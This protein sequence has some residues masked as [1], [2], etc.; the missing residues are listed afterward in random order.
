MTREQIIALLLRG[1]ENEP[2]GLKPH[3]LAKV[4]RFSQK[5]CVQ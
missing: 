5:G 1:I 3:E 4:L 2:Y